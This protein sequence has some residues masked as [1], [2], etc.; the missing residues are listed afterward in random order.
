MNKIFIG[1]Y[2]LTPINPPLTFNNLFPPLGWESLDIK[3]VPAVSIKR[4][5]EHEIAGN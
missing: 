2:W 4:L 1:E 3:G 5:L